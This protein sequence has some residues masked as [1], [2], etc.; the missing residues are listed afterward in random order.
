MTFIAIEG[1][2]GVGKATQAGMLIGALEDRGRECLSIDF[3]QYQNNVFGRLIAQWL[4]GEHGDFVHMPPRDA[5]ILYAA[6]R[7]ESADAIRAA[8]NLGLVVVADRYTASNKIHQGGKHADEA[9][10]ERF[11]GWLENLEHA[12][13]RNPRPDIVIYLDA[14]LEVARALLNRK[15]ASKGGILADGEQDQ[16]EQDREYL[17]HSHEMARWL[18]ARSDDWRMIDCSDGKGG[19]R[20]RAD[21]HADVM[22]AVEPFIG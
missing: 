3:P 8:L 21:I 14:P 22:R 5:S 7:R 18:C 15:R 6:D 2:D 4:A 1:I 17:Q 20:S 13:M 12:I 16:V 10:R 19:M 11:L 9:D